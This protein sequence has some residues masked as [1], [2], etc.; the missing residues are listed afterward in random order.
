MHISCYLLVVAFLSFSRPAEAAA[1]FTGSSEG[2]EYQMN[3]LVDKLDIPWG[4]AFIGPAELLITEKNGRFNL[5]DTKTG[6]LKNL[7]SGLQVQ[8]EG[9]GGLL[10]VAVPPGFQRGDWIYFTYSKPQGR[11]AATTLARGRLYG[12]NL[13]DRQDLLITRSVS[14]TDYHFGSRIAF[15][16]H[17]HVYFSVGDRGERQNG[18]DLASHAGSILRLRMDGSVPG[19]NP[20]V[21]GGGLGEIWTYGHRNPQGLAYDYRRNRLWSNEHGPRGGDEINRIERGGNYGWPTVSHGM[22]YWGPVAVGEATH[23]EGMVDPLKVYIPSIAPGSLLLYEGAAFP[24]WR[25]NLF[26]GALKMRHLNRVVL[27]EAG[28][29]RQEERLL[30][31]LNERIRALAESPEGWLYFSTDSGRI[32]VL[33]PLAASGD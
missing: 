24:K 13:V 6:T 5:L 18:Q 31:E 21:K 10:D 7:Q 33:K 26:S 32:Y 27:D 17:G 29:P 3:L 1:L 23:K 9:Q 19:D 4:M 15:D 2:M 25:G 12:G 16:G 20:F 28:I 14:D 22:E 30:L 8:N 11:Q